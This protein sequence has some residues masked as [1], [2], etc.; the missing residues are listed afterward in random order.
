VTPR[1]Y[2]R[3]VA[4]IRRTDL[5]DG[6][7]HVWCRGVAADTVFP[8]AE[9]RTEFFQL[10]GRCA[11]RFRWELYAACVMSTH[12]HL[13]LDADVDSLSR[14][15][16]QLNWRYA[17]SFNRRHGTFGHVFAERFTVRVLEDESRIFDTCTYVLLNPVKARLCA[18]VEDWP[19]SYSRYGLRA[20]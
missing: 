2:R 9:D 4:R 15:M 1:R 8:A 3:D 17:T 12:Y 7:F 6:Y 19:W 16:H 14:G 20:S 10:I 18:R 13:V 11:R 5:P